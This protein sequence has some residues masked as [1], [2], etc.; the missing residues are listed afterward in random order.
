[1]ISGVMRYEFQKAV[2]LFVIGLIASTGA[3]ADNC[4]HARLKPVHH[5]QGRVIDSQSR[6]IPEVKVILSKNGALLQTRY[7]GKGGWFDFDDLTAG[8]YELRVESEKFA[9][10]TYTIKVTRPK[11]NSGEWLTVH[12]ALPGEC[13]G[14]GVM[15]MRYV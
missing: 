4:V 13:G 11:R 6:P 5:I 14:I 9:S 1:M 3:V 10:A 2:C 8:E 7:T 12:M 15:K